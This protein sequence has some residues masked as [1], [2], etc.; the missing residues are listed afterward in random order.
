MKRI[1]RTIKNSI[2]NTITLMNL[3]AGS[4]GAVMA[5]QGDY[6]AAFWLVV[7]AAV[8]DFCDGLAARLLKAYSPMGRELDSLADVVS[9]GFTPA[10][11]LFSISGSWICFAVALFSAL[12]LARFNIDD[13]QHDT[14]IGLP[15]PANALM[16]VSVGYIF[17]RGANPLIDA[18]CRS[19][20]AVAAFAV[21]MSLLL[22][23]NIPMF[24]LKFKSYGL[25][26]NGVRYGFLLLGAVALALWRIGAVPFIVAAYILYSVFAALVCRKKE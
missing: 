11:V 20:W 22:V 21:V 19:E 18:L 9:F 12:R 3:L 17:A 10:A 2:P 13:R 14:F 25:R 7:A 5:L 23:C 4:A 24:S 16:I 8:F 1:L 15:T 26:G 6:T